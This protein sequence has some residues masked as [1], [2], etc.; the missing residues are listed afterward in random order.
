VASERSRVFV[1]YDVAHDADL[2]DRLLAESRA[3][4]AFV[5]SA[6]SGTGDATPEGEER[7]RD[8]IAAADAV[9]VICGEHTDESP[10]VSAE[11]RIAREERKPHLL[12]WGRRASM[13]KKPSSALSDD[14]MYGWTSD[15]VRVQLQTLMRAKREAP[16]HLRRQ[17]PAAKIPQD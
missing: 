15:V 16:E 7:A 3:S 10:G 17:P 8:S 6:S 11:L 12:L 13:C 2:R 4:S 14:A 9:I 5:V 1:S